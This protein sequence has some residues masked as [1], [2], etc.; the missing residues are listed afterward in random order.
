MSDSDKRRTGLLL[1]LGLRRRHLGLPYIR[2]LIRPLTKMGAV[3]YQFVCGAEART[4]FVVKVG[5]SQFQYALDVGDPIGSILYWRSWKEWEFGEVT[6]FSKW[7]QGARRIL[8]IGAYTGFYALLGA[9]SGSEVIAFEPNPE[10]FMRLQRNIQLNHFES[11]CVLWNL[12]AG[13]NAEEIPFHVHDDDPTCSSAVRPSATQI[14]VQSA[15]VDTVVPLDRRTD[16]VKMDVEGF[17]DQALC[18][19]E[20]ILRDSH[21]KIVF[22]CF[23]KRTAPIVEGLLKDH[24]YK[25]NWIAPDGSVQ[26]IERIAVEKYGHGW[27][28]FAAHI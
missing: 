9:A 20:G 3:R 5:A 16:L 28:N 7:M 1:G 26:P 18:G 4:N 12:A 23:R 11:K 10:A 14:I 24:G 27:H 15:R 25:L 6:L 13:S 17:E 2:S 8:D 22:E 21:P 19:M